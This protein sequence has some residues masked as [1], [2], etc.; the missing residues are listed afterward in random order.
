MANAVKGVQ[1]AER[2]NYQAEPP[3]AAGQKIFEGTIVGSVMVSTTRY[4]RVYQAGDVIL[5]VA[6]MFVDNSAGA[7]GALRVK[8][9]RGCFRYSQNGTITDA[10]ID[11]LCKPVDNQTVAVEATPA[12]ATA[13][14]FG[15]IVEVTP[16]GVWVE[17]RRYSF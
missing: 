10:H 2:D 11:L 6:S 15:R 4:A 9:K 5:G 7:N 8:L 14:T 16:E 17:T 13:N 12:T 1:T 3:V